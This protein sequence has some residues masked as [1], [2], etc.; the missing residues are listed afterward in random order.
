[1]V[2]VALSSIY[3]YIYFKYAFLSDF[4]VSQIL[5]LKLAIF[6]SALGFFLYI[7]LIKNTD[8]CY[9][10]IYYILTFLGISAVGWLLF[11]ECVTKTKIFGCL[12][13]V[14]GLIIWGFS[15]D[16]VASKDT[17]VKNSSRVIS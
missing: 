13:I 11:D 8:S 5:Y 10:A 9:V 6:L 12:L 15:G 1:M 7:A 3:S 17:L 2:F 4:Y 16:L 14:I